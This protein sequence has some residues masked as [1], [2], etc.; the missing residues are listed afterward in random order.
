MKDLF[1]M[2]G[3]TST[4]SILSAGLAYPNHTYYTMTE[5]EQKAQ[6]VKI[7]DTVYKH[8]GF[9]AD[10]LIDIYSKDSG[11]IFVPNDLSWA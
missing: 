8:P 2:T 9:W 1:N 3:G 5:A 4:G 7:G 11:K 10:G 6:E